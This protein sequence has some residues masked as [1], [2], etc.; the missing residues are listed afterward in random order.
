MKAQIMATLGF[1]RPKPAVVEQV[2]EQPKVELIKKIET[3]I[4]EEKKMIVEP[5][6]REVEKPSI[7]VITEKQKE[8]IVQKAPE[9]VILKSPMKE[10]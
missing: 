10:V 6:Q 5:K 8:I 2:K 9:A 3:P 7:P 1:P 4:I